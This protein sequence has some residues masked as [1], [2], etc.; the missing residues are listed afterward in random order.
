MECLYITALACSTM[1]LL[2]NI[3]WLIVYTVEYIDDLLF[4]DF[5]GWSII[6]W[7]LNIF[8]ILIVFTYFFKQ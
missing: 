4:R 3:Y 7:L 8:S 5:F 6:I 1:W 2:S